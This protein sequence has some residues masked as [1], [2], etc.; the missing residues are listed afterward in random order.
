MIELTKD[1]LLKLISD[2]KYGREI[3]D[4]VGENWTKIK[5]FAMHN[6]IDISSVPYNIPKN[7]LSDIDIDAIIKI[8][9]N[10]EMSVT[11]L[12]EKYNVD[13]KKLSRLLKSKGVTVRKDGKKPIDSHYFD[14]ID[15][16]AKAYWLGFLYADGCV[17]SFGSHFYNVEVGLQERDIKQLEK[18]RDALHS[19]HSIS[20]KSAN[21]VYDNGEYTEHPVV[22][23]CFS[24]RYIYKA[25]ISHGCGPNKTFTVQFPTD[26]P[27]E[28]MSHFLRGHFDG[29]GCI[30][31]TNKSR[32][33]SIVSASYDFIQSYKE[34]FKENYDFVLYESKSKSKNGYLYQLGVNSKKSMIWLC[35]YLYADSDESIRLD[36]KYEKAKKYI[37]AV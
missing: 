32:G 22:R 18:L 34:F 6:D 4:I 24:D 20:K 19:K 13:R 12:A 9:N 7:T 1:S 23:I 10:A 16:S 33:M 28:L 31:D 17:G 14:N 25:L 5:Y 29:D 37:T 36:R 2:G 35:N 30:Y 26:I 11:Q 27:F 3:S 15:T 21:L 8:Y